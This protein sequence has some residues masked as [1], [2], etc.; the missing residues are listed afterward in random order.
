ML[1]KQKVDPRNA[2]AVMSLLHGRTNE[3]LLMTQD[4]DLAH[5]Y[6]SECGPD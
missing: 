2:S 6:I 5:T 3:L 1:Q 4:F